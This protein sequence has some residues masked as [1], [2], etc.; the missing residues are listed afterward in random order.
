MDLNNSN[1]KEL[2]ELKD[3]VTKLINLRKNEINQLRLIKERIDINRLNKLGLSIED[4]SNLIQ[5]I[6]G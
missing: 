6:K 5:L 3:K 4:I 1:I 2:K